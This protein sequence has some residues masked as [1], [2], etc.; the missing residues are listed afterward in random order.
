[1]NTRNIA[2]ENCK[3]GEEQHLQCKTLHRYFEASRVLIQINTEALSLPEAFPYL[4]R[5]ISY[6]NSD[7]TE[8]YQNMRKVRRQW[9]MIER[10][11]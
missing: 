11:W 6:N 3:Q 1:M 4:R 8:V 9:R 7:W 10:C 5:T 2:S